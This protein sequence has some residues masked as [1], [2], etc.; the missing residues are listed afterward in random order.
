MTEIEERPIDV[1]VFEAGGQRFGADAA[2]VLRVLRP[3]PGEDVA[4]A[5]GVDPATR[6]ALAVLRDDAALS[7]VGADAITGV[8]RLDRSSLRPVP[9]FLRGVIQ[10]AIIGFAIVDDV[11][12]VLLDLRR[13]APGGRPENPAHPDP[14]TPAP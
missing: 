4:R 10:P 6:R 7:L 12:I 2:Q 1:L 3:G 9:P 11:P 14:P 5:L 13:V 8:R